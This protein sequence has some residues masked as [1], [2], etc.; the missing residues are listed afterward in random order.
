MGIPNDFEAIKAA[1]DQ[2]RSG[3]VQPKFSE[4]IFTQY[5]S[6]LKSFFIDT[7]G[8]EPK[9]ICFNGEYLSHYGL[10]NCVE[11]CGMEVNKSSHYDYEQISLLRTGYPC[12]EN[13]YKPI[14]SKVLVVFNNIF[15]TN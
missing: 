12:K 5:I 8:V 14:K 3:V 15:Y 2:I 11:I 6:L 1:V 10:F 13:N 9:I 4:E 7:H